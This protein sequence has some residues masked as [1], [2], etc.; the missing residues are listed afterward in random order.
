MSKSTTNIAMVGFKGKL[1]KQ[2][3]L[4]RD[5]GN[6]ILASK[7]EIM[8][9]NAAAS[10]I[11]VRNKFHAATEWAKAILQDPV[12]A[13][14]Y[15][16]VAKRRQSA[17]TV[18]ATNYLKPPWIELIDK[19]EYSG[20]IGDKIYVSAFDLY[21]V[22]KVTVKIKDSTGNLIEGGACVKD[23]AGITW[24]YTTTV[25]NATL[26]GST[27]EVVVY[28]LPRNSIEQVVTL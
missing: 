13:A 9:K 17:Y 25:A 14:G 12:N 28:N 18:A 16:S 10:Q 4:R 6:T 24:D 5:H 20:T 3:V 15:K 1:G 21:K 7:P 26:T 19:S 27:I 8:K 23:P 11:A 22:T 2:Y